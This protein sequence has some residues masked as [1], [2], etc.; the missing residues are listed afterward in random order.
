MERALA[1]PARR[2]A[3]L[4]ECLGALARDGR[5]RRRRARRRPSSGARILAHPE[6]LRAAAAER[7]AAGG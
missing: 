4:A 3:R 5:G 2:R 1:D 6:L 7:S